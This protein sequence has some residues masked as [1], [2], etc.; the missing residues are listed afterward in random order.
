MAD[1][2]IEVNGMRFANPFVIGSGPA[3]RLSWRK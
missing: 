3:V 1:L 2:S